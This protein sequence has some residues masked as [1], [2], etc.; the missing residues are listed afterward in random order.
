MGSCP[1]KAIETAH[2]SILLFLLIFSL[3]FLALFYKYFDLYFPAIEN[4]LVK[5]V[6]ESCLYL[7][8]LALWYRLVHWAM[9]FKAVERLMVWTSLTKFKWWGRRYRALSADQYQNNNY[10]NN[11]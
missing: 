3:G 8:L 1:K 6:V 9:R 11:H 2:G 4:G 5:M 10:Q 7:A